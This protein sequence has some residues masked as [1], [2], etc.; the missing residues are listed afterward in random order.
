MDSVVAAHGSVLVLDPSTVHV[1]AG[2]LRADRP[3][4]WNSGGD[5]SSIHL[6]VAVKNCLDAAGIT[7]SQ[8]GAYVFCDG[9]G[10]QL[11]IR[12]AA[13]A[14]RTWQTLR[15]TPAPVFAYRSLVVAALHLAGSTS[16]PFA[17][18]S[19]ARRESW[20]AVRVAADGGVSPVLRVGVGELAGWAEPL[21]TPHG[22]RAWAEPPRPAGVCPYDC[23]SFFAQLGGR[24]LLEQVGDAEP[25][26]SSPTTYATWTGRRHSST[27]A[28]TRSS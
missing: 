12:T 23:G 19:D 10:S 18:V 6:F 1:Q 20:H 11:G 21:F 8:V 5:D 16:A 22:F 3:P 7:P 28:A 13:M 14:L 17:V 24:P 4:V 2:L 26:L 15:R 25:W 9:P 27:T